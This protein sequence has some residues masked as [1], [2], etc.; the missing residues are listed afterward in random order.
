MNKPVA[1]VTSDILGN[2]KSFFM[3]RRSILKSQSFQVIQTACDVTISPVSY[4]SNCAASEAPE[5]KID[6]NKDGV[7]LVMV[8]GFRFGF[9]FYLFEKQNFIVLFPLSFILEP[10]IREKLMLTFLGKL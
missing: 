9:F 6:G 5:E 7:R 2:Q 8:V 3:L 10:P 1:V 4:H